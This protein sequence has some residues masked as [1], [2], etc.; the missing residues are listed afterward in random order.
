MSQ[1]GLLENFGFRLA[2]LCE[3]HKDTHANIVLNSGRTYKNWHKNVEYLIVPDDCEEYLNDDDR[4]YQAALRKIPIVKLSWLDKSLKSGK[5]LDPK[6][7]MVSVDLDEWDESK[8]MKEQKRLEEKPRKKTS[9][10]KK[11]NKKKSSSN[12]KK[13]KKQKEEEKE[14]EDKNN[15]SDAS[16][17]DD[18]DDEE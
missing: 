17:S 10:K 13:T 12:K 7:Y 2:G 18:S 15:Q 3:R 5:V 6:K 1:A 9:S 4:L 8:L 11:Q 14:N 16:D